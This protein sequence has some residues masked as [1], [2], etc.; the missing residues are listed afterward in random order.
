MSKEFPN[1]PSVEVGPF[2]SVR[3]FPALT[4]VDS[5]DLEVRWPS[6]EEEGSEAATNQQPLDP[7]RFPA[8]GNQP[9]LTGDS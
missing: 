2:Y 4:T 8:Q 9:F 6:S 5:S 3:R 1:V 7:L